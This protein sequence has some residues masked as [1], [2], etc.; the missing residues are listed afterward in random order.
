MYA[1]ETPSLKQ[2][3]NKEFLEYT[4]LVYLH[5]ACITSATNIK[6]HLTEIC[7][8]SHANITYVSG[9][10]NCQKIEKHILDDVLIHVIVAK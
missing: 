3:T 6:K 5:N 1:T 7:V 9:D 2:Y 8:L 4:V 10:Y